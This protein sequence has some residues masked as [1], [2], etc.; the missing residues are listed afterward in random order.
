MRTPN[1]TRRRPATIAAALI[2]VFVAATLSTAADPSPSPA[3]ADN[4]IVQTI[5]TAD[6]APLVYNGRVYLYTGHDE[7]GSTTFNMQEWRVWSSDDMANWTDHGSPMNLDTF[8]WA[9]SDA[10]AGQAIERGGKFYWYVPV[11]NDATGGSAIGVAVSDSPTGPFRDALGHP[12]IVSSEIDP[13]V[14]IDTDGQAYLYWGN[15]NLWYVKLN[16]DM[17]S[18]LGFPGPDPPHH[19]GLRHPTRKHGTA[20][21]LRGG[22]VGLQ[23]RIAVLQRVRGAVLLGAHRLLDRAQPHWTLDLPGDGHAA[24]RAAPSP[25]TPG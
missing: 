17:I 13:S 16:A 22:S 24:H 2:A 3:Q 20:D 8:S 14:F 19:G 4:P 23:A 1:A 15:P 7:D 18:L 5:Y 25:T 10:W 11:I 21:P 12:L 9:R 6:P